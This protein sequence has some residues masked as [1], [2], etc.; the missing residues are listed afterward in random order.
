MSPSHLPHKTLLL[1]SVVGLLCCLCIAARP[2]VLN[3]VANTRRLH[4]RS[5]MVAYPYL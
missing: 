2:Y 4:T 1:P 5:K 3:G